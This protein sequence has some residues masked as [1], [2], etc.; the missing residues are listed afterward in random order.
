MGKEI[1]DPTT[2]SFILSLEKETRE[3]MKCNEMKY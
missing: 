3:K 1:V 2:K